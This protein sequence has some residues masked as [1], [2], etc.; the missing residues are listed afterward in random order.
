MLTKRIEAAYEEKAVLESMLREALDAVGREKEDYRRRL[1]GGAVDAP[2]SNGVPR[3]TET[4]SAVRFPAPPVSAVHAAPAVEMSG[5]EGGVEDGGEMPT[6]LFRGLW[7]LLFG[8]SGGEV[9]RKDT[10][11]DDEGRVVAV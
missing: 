7:W 8:G 3:A 4:A 1:E 2:L 9:R 11:D 5:V 6:G 10:A